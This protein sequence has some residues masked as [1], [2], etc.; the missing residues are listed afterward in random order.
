MVTAAEVTLGDVTRAARD[1]GFMG[2]TVIHQGGRKPYLAACMDRE[3][4]I[5]DPR[6]YVTQDTPEAALADLHRQLTAD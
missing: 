4:R 2:I 6:N 1:R 5:C 3:G